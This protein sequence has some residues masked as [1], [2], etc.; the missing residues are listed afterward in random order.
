MTNL[1]TSPPTDWQSLQ[2][3][4]AKIFSECG[5]ITEVTKDITTVRGT[6]NIDVYADDTTQAPTSTYLIECKLWNRPVPKTVVHAF[7]TVVTDFG[8]N[9][10]FII[11]SKGFQKG[12][13]EAAERSNIRLLN[14]VEFLEL[15]R[16]RW[17]QHYMLPYL[18]QECDALVEYTEPI[19]SRI[20]RKADKL[21]PEKQEVFRQLRQQYQALAYY[22]LHISFQRSPAK[23]EIP[24]LPIKDGMKVDYRKIEGGLPPNL[25]EATTL[26]DFLNIYVDHLKAATSAF[27]DLFGE[28]A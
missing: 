26:R 23:G 22:A 6:V 4:A 5:L 19:N 8:A 16:D 7:R 18:F 24:S 15:F 27:D 3:E 20:F 2:T 14:W 9:W 17:T 28:R 13:Y 1:I 12:A 10:G 21:S 25:V 11:S